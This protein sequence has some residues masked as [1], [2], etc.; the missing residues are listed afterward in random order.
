M[1]WKESYTSVGGF[2][3]THKIKVFKIHKIVQEKKNTK[4][5]GDAKVVK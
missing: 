5:A 3:D 4:C 1:N 2:R